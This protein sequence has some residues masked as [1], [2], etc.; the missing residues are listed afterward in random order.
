MQMGTDRPE[1]FPA[2][3][4]EQMSRGYFDQRM[5]LLRHQICHP[6]AGI[7]TDEEWAAFKDVYDVLLALACLGSGYELSS[8]CR[9]LCFHGCWRPIETASPMVTFDE[10]P[11]ILDRDGG[12]TARVHMN[13]L[14]LMQ[15]AIFTLHSGSIL[16]RDTATAW[17]AVVFLV[18][19]ESLCQLIIADTANIKRKGNVQCHPALLFYS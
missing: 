16:L 14:C 11:G 5:D 15:L 1:L 7:Y 17:T 8:N 18:Y 12:D 6:L 19:A 4:T 2:T 13:L 9:Y 10:L 3:T